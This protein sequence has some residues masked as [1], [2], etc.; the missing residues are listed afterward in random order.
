RV[1]LPEPPGVS[2]NVERVSRREHRLDDGCRVL[3]NA[4]KGVARRRLDSAAL[5][6]DCHHVPP[7]APGKYVVGQ[8]V[9]AA[10]L[11]HDA[12]TC[13]PQCSLDVVAQGFVAMIG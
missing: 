10:L 12:V 1:A 2:W 6:A 5:C 13:D 7:C 8:G 4:Q 9:D 11:C 3:L